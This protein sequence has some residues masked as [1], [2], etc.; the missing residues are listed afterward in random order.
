MLAAKLRRVPQRVYMLR[1][2]KLETCTGLKRLALLFAERLASACANVVL[3]NSQS[4]RTQA[5]AL[6]DRSRPQI[7]AAR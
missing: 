3:C 2:L 6:R 5:L 1:G 7:A 4:L